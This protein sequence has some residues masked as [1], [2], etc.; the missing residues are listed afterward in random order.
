MKI[1]AVRKMYH[2]MKSFLNSP[3]G[4]KTLQA[5]TIVSIT[6]LAPQAFAADLLAGTQ[7]MLMETLQG[8]GK[9]YLYIGEC[10]VSLLAYIQTKNVLVLLGIIVVAVFFNVM[11]SVT[12]AKTS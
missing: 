10:I 2:A 8:T 4:V 6:S 7:N 3:K 11:L 9:T 5:V 12:G 1:I